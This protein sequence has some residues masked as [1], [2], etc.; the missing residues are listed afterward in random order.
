MAEGAGRTQGG[1]GETEYVELIRQQREREREIIQGREEMVGK[2][3]RKGER[4]VKAP[5]TPVG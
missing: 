2:K 5:N 1:G 3:G 4:H